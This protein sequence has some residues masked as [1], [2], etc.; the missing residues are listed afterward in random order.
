[1]NETTARSVR[2]TAVRRRGLEVLSGI[3]AEGETVVTSR[4]DAQ[5]I[6][7]NK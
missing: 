5:G 3:G 4:H 1:V 6:A 2:D 7:C